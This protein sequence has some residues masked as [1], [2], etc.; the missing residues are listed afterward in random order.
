MKP[1]FSFLIVVVT[2]IHAYPNSGTLGILGP[3]DFVSFCVLSNVCSATSSPQLG[4]DP[5]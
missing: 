5:D 2:A 4:L 3:H 1:Y